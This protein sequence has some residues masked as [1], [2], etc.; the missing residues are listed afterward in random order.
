MGV[1][2]GF[3]PILFMALLVPG[4]AVVFWESIRF[5][6]EFKSTNLPLP[7]PWPWT[8]NFS[9]APLGEAIR[10]V[11]VGLFYISIVTFGVLSIMWAAR[12]KF[13]EKHVSPAL[14]AASFLTLPY[15][16]HAYVRADVSHLA[17]GIF[18]FLIGCLV[19]L[20]GQPKKIK[21]PLALV[22]CTAS[23]WVMPVFHPGWKCRTSE[24]CVNIEISGSDMIVD[25]FEA[26]N[27]EL[28]RRLNDQFSPNGQ[29]FIAT[30]YWPGA[31]SLLERKSPMWEIYATLPRSESFEKAE[32]ERI[33]KARPG[34][35]LVLDTPLDEREELRYRNTHPLIHKC[36]T[37][38]FERLPDV[39]DPAYH[40]YRARENPR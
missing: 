30:P 40:I 18:P 32:I 5:L 37:E 10:G 28:L 13:Q 24:Q 8:A 38:H 26:Y 16:H 15:A 14:V 3:I 34:F 21:W 31:Y 19:L 39:P 4:F 12:Q 23:L 7:V 9:S 27:V 2:A 22:L 29:S 25:P 20:A 17:Q 35:V 6:F 33:R 11:L 36:I 1:T